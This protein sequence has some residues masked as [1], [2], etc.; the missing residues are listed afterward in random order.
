MHLILLKYT[1]SIEEIEKHIEAHVMFLNENY[2]NNKFIF[3]GRKVPRTGGVILANNCTRNEVSKI[4]QADPFYINKV[5]D[6]EIIEF[7]PTKYAKAFESFI[8]YNN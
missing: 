2:K 4:I 1:K 8:E 7:T 6:Y 3:S 5:A